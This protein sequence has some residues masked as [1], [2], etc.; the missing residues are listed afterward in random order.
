MG[1]ASR[2]EFNLM[3]SAVE[4]KSSINLRK[5]RVSIV[6]QAYLITSTIYMREELLKGKHINSIVAD[7]LNWLHDNNRIDLFAHVTMPDHLHFIAVL[8][9]GTLSEVM[10][11]LKS[12]T[13][14]KINKV[15]KREG[16]VWQDQYHDRAIRKEKDLKEVIYYCL[17][18]PVRKNLV[19]DYR[20]YPYWYCK[21]E[22]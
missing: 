14:K 7:A 20:N 21:W 13:S 18:N 2:R 16:R 9:A 3:N 22:V 10:H 4:I 1:A 11:S 6:G 5:G 17:N 12:F 8:K 15:L 19:K